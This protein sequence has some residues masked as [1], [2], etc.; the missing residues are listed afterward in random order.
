MI[1]YICNQGAIEDSSRSMRFD[2]HC[3][4][5]ARM[6]RY[7]RTSVAT[8]EEIFEKSFKNPLTNT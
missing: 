6:D 3:V 7:K 1:L 4:V 5:G 8:I 2:D